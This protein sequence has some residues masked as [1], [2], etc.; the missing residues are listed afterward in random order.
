MGYIEFGIISVIISIFQGKDVGEE[1][2]RLNRRKSQYLTTDNLN[3]GDS[4]KESCSFNKLQWMS[5]DK[6]MPEEK[7]HEIQIL[8]IPFGILKSPCNLK[9]IA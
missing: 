3:S 1:K 7:D 6:C 5:D 8:S 4:K 9:D 2:E